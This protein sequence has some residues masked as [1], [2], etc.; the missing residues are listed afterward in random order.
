MRVKTSFVKKHAVA[1]SRTG[2]LVVCKHFARFKS[3]ERAAELFTICSSLEWFFFYYFI[4]H[5]IQGPK[6]DAAMKRDDLFLWH[7]KHCLLRKMSLIM[8]DM[9]VLK[10]LDA[11]RKSMLN[12]QSCA[13][14]AYL[15]LFLSQICITLFN[16][17]IIRWIIDWPF[18]LQLVWRTPILIVLLFS[19]RLNW[20]WFHEK[21][22]KKQTENKF[23]KAYSVVW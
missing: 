8:I 19:A 21:K 3:P 6:Y 12:M 22:K 23:S 18:H 2:F 16:A 15:S 10:C 9:K 14:N 17:A 7:D 1:E 11:T 13:S 4:L 20:F 5:W